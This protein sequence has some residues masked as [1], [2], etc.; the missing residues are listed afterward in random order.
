MSVDV[1][2]EVYVSCDGCGSEIYGD[3]YTVLCSDCLPSLDSLGNCTPIF[4]K[5]TYTCLMSHQDFKWDGELPEYCPR[6]GR[7]I[8]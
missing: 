2:T 1:E 7:Q 8:I 3:D 5:D 6:C 4:F